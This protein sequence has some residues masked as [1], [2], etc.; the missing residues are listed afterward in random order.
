MVT[1]ATRYVHEWTPLRAAKPSLPPFFATPGS[2]PC[3]LSPG[4]RAL[5][6]GSPQISPNPCLGPITS[7]PYSRVWDRPSP[8][9]P[10]LPRAPWQFSLP[11]SKVLQ[12]RKLSPW[13]SHFHGLG[14]LPFPTAS[15]WTPCQG[16]MLRVRG[17]ALMCF[18]P[19]PA[20]GSAI[21]FATP[22]TVF[23]PSALWL[24]PSPLPMQRRGLSELLIWS[25]H[26]P[27]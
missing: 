25:G 19:T 5:E 26:S 15:A 12:A 13:H 9:L 23:L 6:L 4:C 20:P 14:L 1:G 11:L 10:K 22:L 18:T 8:T 27:A 3:L 16:R 24:Q 21:F 2:H 17:G 7:V